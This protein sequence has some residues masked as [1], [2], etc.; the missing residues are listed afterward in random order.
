MKPHRYMAIS[1]TCMNVTKA[2]L[3][4]LQTTLIWSDKTPVQAIKELCLVRVVSTVCFI[5]FPQLYI[6]TRL[7]NI[8]VELIM[9]HYANPYDFIIMIL[10]SKMEQF[11]LEESSEVDG[12][13][14]PKKV[15]TQIEAELCIWHLCIL[16]WRSWWVFLMYLIVI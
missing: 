11:G 4:F 16:H 6:S 8:D 5:G 14:R 1:C 7:S 9:L 13:R 15:Y 3:H 10:W 12:F 2:V